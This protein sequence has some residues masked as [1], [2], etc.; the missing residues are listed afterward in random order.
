M[1]EFLE[2]IKNIETLPLI[3]NFL[4]F[5]LGIFCKEFILDRFFKTLNKNRRKIVLD[6]SMR[7]QLFTQQI[8]SNSDFDELKKR[9]ESCSCVLIGKILVRGDSNTSTTE[10]ETTVFNKKDIFPLDCTWRFIQIEN[11]SS[12]ICH[13]NTINQS[14]KQHIKIASSEL[15]C[16]NANENIGI[17][18]DEYNKPENIILSYHG[19]SIKYNI[20][21]TKNIIRGDI[22]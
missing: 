13:V 1:D 9:M 17:I 7:P 12:Y 21:E 10:L 16:I 14:K 18:I 15:T 2:Y 5:A 4:C 11:P 19:F 3:I 22:L 8:K 6:D 20:S